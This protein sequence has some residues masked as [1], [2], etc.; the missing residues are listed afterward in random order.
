MTNITELRREAREIEDF[1]REPWAD[2]RT[3]AELVRAGLRDVRDC[4]Q[5]PTE[6]ELPDVASL[7]LIELARL[8]G[9][10]PEEIRHFVETTRPVDGADVEVIPDGWN[11]RAYFCDKL[12]D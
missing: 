6:K 9:L 11:P 5:M 1:F 3:P 10:T 4:L 2:E 7:D 12:D 8:S